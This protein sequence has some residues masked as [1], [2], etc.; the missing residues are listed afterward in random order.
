[1]Q[2]ASQLRDSLCDLVG[3]PRTRTLQQAYSLLEGDDIDK[4][5]VEPFTCVKPGNTV[6]TLCKY[7]WQRIF[8]LNVDNCLE[9]SLRPYQRLAAGLLDLEV[10]NFNDDFS[11]LTPVKLQSIV[12][13]HGYVEDKKSGFIFSAL[14]YAKNISRPNSWMITLSQL[15]RT[16]PFIIVGTT[17]DEIDFTYYVEQR[18]RDVV[19]YDTAPS[20]LIEPKPDRLTRKLC[21]DHGLFLF[22]GTTCEFFSHLESE[23]GSPPE[24]WSLAPLDGLSQM[25]LPKS[26][27]ISFSA[28]FELVPK[29]QVIPVRKAPFLLGADLSWGALE[30]KAD[31]PRE[32]ARV[33][34]SKVQAAAKEK[35]RVLLLLADPGSGKTAILKKIAYQLAR[36]ERNVFWFSG[37]ELISYEVAARVIEDI[38]GPSFFFVDDWID[39]ASFVLRILDLVARNDIV[40]I[41]AERSYRRQYVENSFANEEIEILEPQLDLQQSEARRL[42]RLLDSEALSAKKIKDDTE[43]KSLAKAIS[44]EPIAIASC[45]VQNNFVPFDNIVSGILRESTIDEMNVYATVGISRFCYSGGVHR[46][47][48]MDAQRTKATNE[49]MREDAKLPITTSGLG[50]GFLIPARSVVA[51]RVIALLRRNEPKTLLTIFI[52]LANALSARVN[53]RQISVET[54]ASRLSGSLMDFDRIVKRFIGEDAEEFYEKIKERW[55]WNSRYWEQCALLKL[56]RFLVDRSDRKLLDEAIQNARYAYSIEQHPLSL[57]TLAKMLFTAQEEYIGAKSDLFNEAWNLIS[58]SIEK[59]SRWANMKPTAFVVCFNGVMKFVDAGGILDGKQAERLRE[60]LAITEKKNIKD[61]NFRRLRDDVERV[62]WAK[63]GG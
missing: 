37:K 61:Q 23:F 54:P 9:V 59:E 29:G 62:I 17:L 22:E 34:L 42:I 19:R 32:E 30:A 12:H 16:E 27:K 63:N 18:S 2:S 56:D 51:D 8:T 5:I 35:N 7:P 20:I 38:V 52:N 45:R 31:V 13:L 43:L 40:F 46:S 49:L 39:H 53:R 21:E 47:V 1:M 50:A 14:E 25:S 33:L 6:E 48:L 36:V 10:I 24:Y 41:G 11:E 44:G 4:Y 26:E 57:T 60:I 28:T 58:E 3:I 15:L 55:G